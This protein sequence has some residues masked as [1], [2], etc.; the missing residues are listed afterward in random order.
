MGGIVRR[1]RRMDSKTRGFMNARHLEH[2][3]TTPPRACFLVSDQFRVDG[4]IHR[5]CGVMARGHDAVLERAASDAQRLEKMGKCRHVGAFVIE[6]HLAWRPVF[7]YH[8]ANPS[9]P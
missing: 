4:S 6:M 3:Q 7:D 8:L 5:Q 9:A 1:H 2:D